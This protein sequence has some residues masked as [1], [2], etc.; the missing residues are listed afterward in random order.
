LQTDLTGPGRTAPWTDEWLA[1]LIHRATAAS[2][3]GRMR[4]Q[5]FVASKLVTSLVSLVA[6]PLSLLGQASPGFLEHWAVL[7]LA[8]LAAVFV[9]SRWGW[10]D[11]AQGLVSAALALF[12]AYAVIGSGGSLLSAALALLAVPL[13]AMA[14]GTRR[15]VALSYLFALLGLLLSFMLQGMGLPDRSLSLSAILAIA[16]AVVLGHVVARLLMDRQL[17]GL[18][19]TSAR[20][21][22]ERE[23]ETLCA[24]GDLVTWHDANGAILRSN[25]ASARLLGLSPSAVQGDGLF[26]R[27]HVADRPVFL[28]AVSDGING[29]GSARAC[30]RVR[31][32]EDAS[33]HAMIWLDM[34]VH[35]LTLDGDD[36]CAAV[37]IMRDVSEYKRMEE[38][39]DSTRRETLN[40]KEARADLLAML[41]QELRA[42]LNA[43][44]GYSEILT[45]KGG[46][47]L[48]DRGQS[49]AEL[50]H[51]SGE[52]VLETVN[53]ALDLSS[54]EAGRCHLT[55]G[56]FDMADLVQECCREMAL[57]AQRAGIALSH[58]LVP[59]L[60]H[61]AADRRACRQILLNLLSE[62]VE[63]TPRDG[64]VSV[65]A[66]CEG[67]SVMLSV[68]GTG[69][70]ESNLPRLGRPFLHDPI[71]N[72]RETESSLRLSAVRGLVAL[73]G[74]RMR[75]IGAPGN[76]V[77]VRISL[78]VGAR[79]AA[80]TG[81]LP[82]EAR[83]N[84]DILV[85]KTG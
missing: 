7:T 80:A 57:P 17:A 14:S 10:L 45:G 19:A 67:E 35:R 9:L 40:A 5:L 38:E 39:R 8:P 64:H 66:H 55:F 71:R 59:G 56:E 13:E 69:M 48:A 22:A 1:G 33:A 52:H 58:A 43:I 50:I 83:S 62:V 12:V 61:L 75:M 30:F 84:H 60:P 70:A 21:G 28:K 32:G 16:G 26:G 11:A 24:I 49:Y 53:A 41:S 27:I 85:L 65:D 6:L 73:H 63:S 81:S 79:R 20:L 37:A 51:Q 82:E 74:G 31:S 44:I 23:G 18:I 15:G 47:R 29:A 42:P 46:L 54:I 25:G 76:G 68:R 3:V 72:K 2:P 36:R 78:P 34:R 4:R 77:C